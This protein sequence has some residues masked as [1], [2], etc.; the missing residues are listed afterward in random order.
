M[1]LDEVDEGERLDG[2]HLLV[3]HVHKVCSLGLLG[4]PLEDL[5]LCSRRGTR[6][7]REQMTEVGLFV[8]ILHFGGGGGREHGKKTGAQGGGGGVGGLNRGSTHR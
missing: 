2:L 7:G 5:L 3:A 4:G 8:R 6:R 1:S